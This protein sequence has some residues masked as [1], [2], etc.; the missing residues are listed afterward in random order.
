MLGPHIIKNNIHP[1]LRIVTSEGRRVFLSTTPNYFTGVSSESV[2][3]I[4]RHW[5]RSLQLGRL[6]GQERGEHLDMRGTLP[7]TFPARRCEDIIW[8][9]ALTCDLGSLQYSAESLIVEEPLGLVPGLA[10]PS[11]G[12]RM[13]IVNNRGAPKALAIIQRRRIDR[14]SACSGLFI[15]PLKFHLCSMFRTYRNPA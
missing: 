11:L 3:L 6:S 5:R 13:T 2:W 10:H 12:I 15:T 1:P 14:R 7:P 9:V 8:T 4:Y